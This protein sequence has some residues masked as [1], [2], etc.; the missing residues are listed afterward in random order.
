MLY[1]SFSFT[2]LCAVAAWADSQVNLA[3]ASS[4]P[5]SCVTDPTFASCC[6][7]EHSTGTVCVDGELYDFD[8]GSFTQAYTQILRLDGTQCL[9]K[10]NQDLDCHAVSWDTKEKTCSLNTNS[11]NT[12]STV[13][14]FILL[15]KKGPG[16]CKGSDDDKD[17]E[18][19]IEALKQC[20]ITNA[21]CTDSLDKCGSAREECNSKLSQCESGREGDA[22]KCEDEKKDCEQKKQSCEDAKDACERDTTRRGTGIDK[23]DSDS[24]KDIMRSVNAIRLKDPC[25]LNTITFTTEDARGRWNQWEILCDYYCNPDSVAA[26]SESKLPDDKVIDHILQQQERPDYYGFSWSTN[27]VALPLFRK[28]DWAW[29]KCSWTQ[30]IADSE[31]NRYHMV[32]RTKAFY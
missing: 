20:T 31:G 22:V 16:D 18:E 27:G 2:V 32:R 24:N 30:G 17:C 9:Q 1:I 12:W 19:Q 25:R 8:C 10:C 15:R 3:P 13:P 11:D 29:P 23:P 4:S 5:S 21:T 14:S 6:P 26:T 7:S 28:T